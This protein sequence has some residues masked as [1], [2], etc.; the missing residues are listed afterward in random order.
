MAKRK[1]ERLVG[2][3]ASNQ[4][5]LAK[6]VSMPSYKSFIFARVSDREKPLK[7][8][9]EKNSDSPTDPKLKNVHVLQGRNAKLFIVDPK[10]NLSKE[11]MEET[12]RL[13]SMWV[14]Q[15]NLGFST[16]QKTYIQVAKFIIYLSENYQLKSLVEIDRE[17]FNAFARTC[18]AHP[19]LAKNV[20]ALHPHV[21][22]KVL[23]FNFKSHGKN[24]NRKKVGSFD[25]VFQNKAF[26]DR[27][28]FQLLGF[29]LYRIE[30]INSLL[31]DLGSADQKQL[32]EQGFLISKEDVEGWI[33]RSDVSPLH[34]ICSLFESQPEKAIDL[35]YQNYLV[36]ANA[37]KENQTLPQD[38]EA[39]FFHTTS[40]KVS[41][42]SYKFKESFL[43]F[44]ED[45]FE[46]SNIG[47]NKGARL[48]FKSYEKTFLLKIPMNEAAIM[49]YIL[50]QTGINLEVL[51]TLKRNYG[52]IHWKQRYDINLGT[53]AQSLTKRQVLRLTGTKSKGL[54]GKKPVDIR[55]PV[56][57]HLYEV[58]DLWERLFSKSDSAVFFSGISFTSAIR[59]FCSR[60]EIFNDESE[61][62]THIDTTKIRKTFAGAKLAKSVELAGSGEEL[63][64]V[65]REALNHESFDTTIFSYLM[66]TDA[67]NF[68]YSSAVVALTTKMIEDALSFKGKIKLKKT[69]EEKS[70][71]IPVFLCDCQNPTNPTHDIPI[72]GRCKQY[73]LCL[74]C[75][76]SEVYSEHIPRICYRIL[77]YDMTPS[78]ASDVLADRKS[79]A[80]DCIERFKS[81][82]PDGELIVDQGFLQARDA[83]VKNTP[84]L[85]PIL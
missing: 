55:V 84:M 43:Q 22:S 69:V 25:E 15:V 54:G 47:I 19:S 51:K 65:L 32:Q 66:R 71:R 3:K 75:E 62:L 83:V 76:R 10:L 46:P 11:I 18:D 70:E 5:K 6:I 44:L 27:E 50:A 67:G 31:D 23:E 45:K 8:W 85:P 80:L 24:A 35:L 59:D 57:S 28:M 38:A 40:H 56:Q 4:T 53:D 16:V 49:L 39:R 74:G 58:I 36:V 34:R 29:V 79:I 2:T 26:S 52:G 21:N 77:Q 14:D 81:E 37:R 7:I 78:P 68:V 64:R 41:I 9:F 1:S 72:A 63:S 82:H 61:R 12:A 48:G 13:F 33:V 30:L 73:D 60:Y 20:L 17:T 42:H